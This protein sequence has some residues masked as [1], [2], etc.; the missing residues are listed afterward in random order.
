MEFNVVA[1]KL[2]ENADDD[3]ILIEILK[4]F[5]ELSNNDKRQVVEY[6]LGALSKAREVAG[7]GP[8]AAG[9]K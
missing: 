3:A 9:A 8:K 4:D 1:Q 6:I 5:E 2:I 7:Y